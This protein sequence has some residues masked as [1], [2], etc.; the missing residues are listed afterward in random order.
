MENVAFKILSQ[1]WPWRGLKLCCFEVF[2][3]KEP[4]MRFFKFFWYT[5]FQIFYM[6]LQYQT[7]NRLTF[8][9][10]YCFQGFGPKVVPPGFYMKFLELW[11]KS[12]PRTFQIFFLKLQQYKGWKLAGI[13]VW[14]KILYWS[15]G[16]KRGLNDF[17]KFYANQ[18]I[19]FFWFFGWSF[20]SVR[21]E[22]LVK[23]FCQNSWFWGFW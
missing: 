10:S 6:K 22:K 19:E 3:L 17:C 4:K 9:R 14:K 1:K 12:A 7:Q 13:F 5:V 15:F 18:C 2:E 23:L 21:A 8:F 11:E 20:N 16:A